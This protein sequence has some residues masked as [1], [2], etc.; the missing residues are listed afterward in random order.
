MKKAVKS[1]MNLAIEKR[2]FK[3]APANKF[4]AAARQAFLATVAELIGQD[5]KLLRVK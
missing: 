4:E 2:L 3:D 5:G 1:K